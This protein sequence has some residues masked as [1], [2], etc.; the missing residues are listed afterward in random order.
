MRK[1]SVIGTE[2]TKSLLCL[3]LEKSGVVACGVGDARLRH[4]HRRRRRRRRSVVLQK[5]QNYVGTVK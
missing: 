1:N 2:E 4:G 5:V 3:G